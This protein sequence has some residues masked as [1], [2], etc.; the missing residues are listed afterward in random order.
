MSDTRPRSAS[1][2]WAATT[3]LTV[4]FLGLIVSAAGA[5]DRVVLGEYFT[6]VY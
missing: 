4:V 6:N 3:L 5:A 2:R 1:P